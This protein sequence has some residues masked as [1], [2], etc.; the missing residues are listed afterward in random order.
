LEGEVLI[1]HQFFLRLISNEFEENKCK[2]RIDE[3]VTK[4]EKFILKEQRDRSNRLSTA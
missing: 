4:P 1:R 2:M 3:N